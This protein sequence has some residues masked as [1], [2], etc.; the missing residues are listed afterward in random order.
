MR[1]KV[2]FAYAY[3]SVLDNQL[4]ISAGL[5]GESPW[6]T[7][8]PE[9]QMELERET[10]DNAPIMGMRFEFKP[11]FLPVLNGLNVGFVVNRADNTIPPDAVRTFG[12]MLR[13]SVLGIAWEHDYFA[14]RFAYRFDCDLKSD[15]SLVFGES[16]LYRVEERVLGKFLPGMSVS[17]NGYCI[18]IG[19]EGKGHGYGGRQIYI[20]NWLY[21]KYDPENFIAGLNVGYLDD[22]EAKGQK[23]EFRP[24]FYY[25]LFN[26]LL[27]AGL[28][29]GMEIG[30]KNGKSFD[31]AFYNFW[32]LEPQVKVNI[33]GNFYAALVYRYTSGTFGG[34]ADK[35]QDTHWVNL[36]LCYTF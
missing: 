33:T 4:K 29:G 6:G 30:F 8:G 19:A 10:G 5:L 20:Q 32:F 31:D 36:R 22:F 14:F 12:D 35:D 7:G 17:A 34:T 25:K 11:T 16:L 26:N 2:Y 3:G 24:Y 28:M 9:L 18:G 1:V 15:A 21:A 27:N 23:L 13:E